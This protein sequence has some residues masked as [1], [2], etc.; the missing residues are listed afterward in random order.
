M[1]GR[2][3]HYIPQALLRG[4][5]QANGKQFYTWMYRRNA[6]KPVNPNITR[7]VGVETDFYTDGGDDEIDAEITRSETLYGDALASLRLK[8]AAALQESER[9]ILKR[10]VAHCFI[11]TAR[12]RAIL[13]AAG[14]GAHSFLKRLSGEPRSYFV[15]AIDHAIDD[16]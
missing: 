12:M 9:T 6:E 1:S 11:R 16:E 13:G 10:F 15:D 5:A 8:G 3:H 14:S 4:F 7:N 2:R